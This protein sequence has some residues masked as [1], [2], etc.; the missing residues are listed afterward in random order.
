MPEPVKLDIAALQTN[1]KKDTA[2]FKNGRYTDLG[3][4]RVEA[5]QDIDALQKEGYSYIIDKDIFKLAKDEPNVSTAYNTG[6]GIG[7]NERSGKLYGLINQEKAHKRMVSDI[8]AEAASNSLFIKPAFKTSSS[9]ETNTFEENTTEAPNTLENIPSEVDDLSTPIIVKNVEVG[10]NLSNIH[11]VGIDFTNQVV[12]QQKNMPINTSGNGSNTTTTTQDPK[13]SGLV[14]NP[15]NFKFNADIIDQY[16]DILSGIN[17]KISS[18]KIPEGQE[19]FRNLEYNLEEINKLETKSKTQKLTEPERRNL[20]LYKKNVDNLKYKFEASVNDALN[21]YDNYT[22]PNKGI[23]QFLNGPEVIYRVVMDAKQYSLKSPEH[24]LDLEGY[25]N[26]KKLD[27]KKA[28]KALLSTDFTPEGV[29]K[30]WAS[31]NNGL[32]KEQYDSRYNTV[33]PNST[34]SIL[35][36]LLNPDA[37]NLY[38]EQA[39]VAANKIETESNKYNIVGAF[40]N[41]RKK[42]KM[43]E[44]QYESVEK[45]NKLKAPKLQLSFKKGGVMKFKSAFPLPDEDILN[46]TPEEYNNYLLSL[47]NTVTTSTPIVRSKGID[48]ED[49]PNTLVNKYQRRTAPVNTNSLSTTSNTSLSNNSINDNTNNNASDSKIVDTYGDKGKN[50]ST[51]G[52]KF[53]ANTAVNLGADIA[54]FILARRAYKRPVA[55]VATPFMKAPDLAAIPVRAKMRLFPEESMAAKQ[56]TVYGKAYGGSDAMSRNLTNVMQAVQFMKQ[57]NEIAGK[58]AAFAR[59][60]DARYATDVA[61]N[62]EVFNRKRAVDAEV[63]NKNAETAYRA[64]TSQAEQNMKREADWLANLQTI[65]NMN[66]SRV[67]KKDAMDRTLAA[68]MYSVEQ[69]NA[70]E[71]KDA[72]ETRIAVRENQLLREGKDPDTDATLDKM[73]EKLE[74]ISAPSYENILRT[75]RGFS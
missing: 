10:S 5:L 31:L 35:T 27:L 43:I 40:L 21:I 73:K 46:M 3:K 70:E 34:T 65:I 75:V 50:K 20:N 1:L 32:V 48:Y 12:A 61:R 9:S 18:I 28:Y 30:F 49:E 52:L 13:T 54:N 38:Q 2:F 63:A 7:V 19:F 64:A 33:D 26:K 36:N 39:K 16:S 71:T 59:Q 55:T 45:Y 23:R 68:K 66:A 72:L 37:Q 56:S 62:T 14:A 29:V 60:E 22:T 57:R 58:E 51:E 44:K 67:S 53:N 6:I 47:N 25:G 4:K 8:L 24:A 17:K 15:E 69:A 11:K 41:A 42:R 74:T